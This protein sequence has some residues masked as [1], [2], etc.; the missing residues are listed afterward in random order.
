MDLKFKL[1]FVFSGPANISAS[2]VSKWAALLRRSAVEM[3]FG[4][5]PRADLAVTP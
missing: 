5:A 3:K 2:A 4:P 1:S